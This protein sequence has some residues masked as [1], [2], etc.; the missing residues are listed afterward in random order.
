MHTHFAGSWAWERRGC[1]AGGWG[2]AV[3]ALTFEG[4]RGMGG[5]GGP[6]GG[7]GGRGCGRRLRG[8]PPAGRMRWLC[9]M[10]NAVDPSKPL[11]LINVC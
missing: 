2:A 4:E 9:A 6:R 7:R 1:G 10:A 8:S 11:D 3:E 5:G